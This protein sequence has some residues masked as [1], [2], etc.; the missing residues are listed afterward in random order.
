M[1]ASLGFVF[2]LDHFGHQVGR[3]NDAWVGVRSRDD[4]FH[5]RRSVSDDFQK[6]FRGEQ[7]ATDRR[8]ALIDHHQV[9][10]AA[11]NRLTDAFQ[12]LTGFRDIFRR[13]RIS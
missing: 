7:A 4:Q 3:F 5:R 10:L 1:G 13:R 6:F 9:V 8:I 11:A 2:D 12:T